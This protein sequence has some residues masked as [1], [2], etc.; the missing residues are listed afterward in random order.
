MY[1]IK[2]VIT[3]DEIRRTAKLASEIWNEHFIPIIGKAQV[4]YM[5]EKFQSER[6]IS[7]MLAE[8][9]KYYMIFSENTPAGYC[10]VHAEEGGKLFLSKLYVKREYRGRGYSRLMLDNAI[11]EN[12]PLTSV[13]LTVNKH[14]DNTIEIY[15]HIGFQIKDAVVSDIEGGFVMDDYIMELAL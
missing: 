6:A 15:K 8:G 3:N 12:A 10:G 1:T 7:K 9:Y 11:C 4:D 14:N 5:L 2:Q 13:Y